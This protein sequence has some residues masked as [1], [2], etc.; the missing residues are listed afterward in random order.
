MAK[1]LVYTVLPAPHHNDIHHSYTQKTGKL[2]GYA[3][4]I[5]QCNN[6]TNSFTQTHTRCFLKL[7]LPILRLKS[8]FFSLK[9][10]SV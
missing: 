8:D 9:K 6:N 1:R 10:G 7:V 3:Y 2:T 5:A 4:K